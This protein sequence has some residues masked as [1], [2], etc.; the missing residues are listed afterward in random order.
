MELWFDDEKPWNEQRRWVYSTIYL[1]WE[2]QAVTHYF[3]VE[4]GS[5]PI[6]ITG[7]DEAY[8]K[9]AFDQVQEPG[10]PSV[11]CAYGASIAFRKGLYHVTIRSHNMDLRDLCIEEGEEVDA[12]LAF[13][14]DLAAKVASRIP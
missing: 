5:V 14:I 2:E 9:V 10:E 7:T 1:R 6:N 13:V 4:E 12:E 11:N 8:M 3:Y